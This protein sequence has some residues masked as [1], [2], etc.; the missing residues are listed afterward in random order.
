MEYPKRRQGGLQ[1]LCVSASN[2]IVSDEMETVCNVT[3][4]LLFRLLGITC[5][6]RAEIISKYGRTI[7][8]LM[9]VMRLIAEQISLKETPFIT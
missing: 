7:G 3:V 4:S 8:P 5:S 1:K 2:T 6:Y 9:A